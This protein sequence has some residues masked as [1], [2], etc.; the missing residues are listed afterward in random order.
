MVCCKIFF[1]FFLLQNVLNLFIIFIFNRPRAILHG[2]IR[3][4]KVPEYIK[5][6]GIKLENVLKIYLGISKNTEIDN[7][8]IL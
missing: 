1:A 3:K 7:K 4:E 2:F 5:C 6:G 8:S